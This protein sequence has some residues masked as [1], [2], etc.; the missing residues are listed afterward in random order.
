MIY[1][2]ILISFL[3]GVVTTAISIRYGMSLS[4]RVIERTKEGVPIFDKAED[5]IVTQTHTSGISEI[6]EEEKYEDE[7]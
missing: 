2:A 3:L 5:I 1:I 6:E 4:A 7:E